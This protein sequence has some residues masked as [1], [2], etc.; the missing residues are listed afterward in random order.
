MNVKADAIKQITNLSVIPAIIGYVI[1]SGIF[2]VYGR[3][4]LFSLCFI[5]VGIMGLLNSLSLNFLTFAIFRISSSF[6]IVGCVIGSVI[7]LFEFTDKS[8]N[9]VLVYVA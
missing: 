2:D 5:V 7:M 4:K 9:S 8:T 6:F 3:N 1:F